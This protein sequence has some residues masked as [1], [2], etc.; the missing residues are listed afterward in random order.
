MVPVCPLG[1]EM[2]E[3]RD[4]RRLA[5]ILAADIV[6]Y[7]RLMG[8]DESGTLAQ[9]KSLRKELIDPKVAEYNG[10][11]VKT[12]GDGL[13]IEFPSVLD[14][15]QCAVDVQRS[16]AQRNTHVPEDKRVQFRMGINLG[17]VIVEEDDIYGDGINIASRLEG[18]AD[19]GGICISRKV[20]DDVRDKVGLRFNDLGEQTLKNITRPVQ[21]FSVD[22][23]ST[24]SEQ[25]SGASLPFP[26]KP[27]IAVLP[28]D[29]MSGD[30]EQ[31]YFSDGISED[32]ITELSRIGW[33]FVIARNS[34][35][36]FKGQSPDVREV[37]R[38]LGVRYVL[39][40]SVRKIGDRVRISAQLIDGTTANHLWA[41]RYDRGLK[42]IFEVQDEITQ[43]VVSAIEPELSRAEQERVAR[44][45]PENWDAWDHYQRSLW[46]VWH[47]TKADTFEAIRLS[48]RAI[49]LDPNFSSAYA[50]F[51]W[52]NILA[53]FHGYA[54][55]PTE[56]LKDAREAAEQALRL[57]EQESF[58]YF[59]RGS[60]SFVVRD[61]TPALADVRRS[62]ELNPSFAFGHS[63]TGLILNFMGK[64]KEA[65]PHLE[66]AERLSPRDP[67]A[68]LMMQG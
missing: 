62:T 18:L 44:K 13:L 28:F 19:P 38:A 14:A 21:A 15:V 61:L 23:A 51:A 37:S 31:E 46:H 3:V 41:E 27:S 50:A 56:T 48:K 7:S 12:T 60:A 29:N 67:T 16:I 25:T 43:M 45:P 22:L 26:D 54:E 32:I 52:A 68:W 64:P 65:I 66:I 6:G 39:E 8:V 17:D 63:V 10:N 53:L 4:K 2:A 57:N 9:I 1:G 30:P 35:F 24:S 40:G 20:H 59:T 49:G 5:A 36:S 33:L 55:T 42:D 58:A 11:V 34:S 47:F